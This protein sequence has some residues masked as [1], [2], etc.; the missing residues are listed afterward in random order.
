MAD[1]Y[2]EINELTDKEQRV[3]A[4]QN[5]EISEQVDTLGYGRQVQ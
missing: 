3:I 2:N 4:D 1:K 5:N